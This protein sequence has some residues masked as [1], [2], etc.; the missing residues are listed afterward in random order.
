MTTVRPDLGFC[1]SGIATDGYIVA[2]DAGL[3]N[4]D[5]IVSLDGLSLAELRASV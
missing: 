4:G 3:L 5:V 1:V 2:R